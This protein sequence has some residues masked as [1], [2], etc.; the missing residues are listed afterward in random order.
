MAINVEDK[1]EKLT[2]K[3]DKLVTVMNDVVTSLAV[4]DEREKHAERRFE[5]IED[6]MKG[7]QSDVSEIKESRARE[8]QS[9]TFVYKYW[10]ALIGIA[11]LVAYKS[12]LIEKM[13][14]FL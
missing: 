2:D 5:S 1:I 9:R 10:P 14:G 3:M 4:R 11:A 8:E 13:I 7:M 6:A 12:G